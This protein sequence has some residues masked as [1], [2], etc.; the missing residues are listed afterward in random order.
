VGGY[1]RLAAYT[2]GLLSLSL[3]V[4]VGLIG[5]YSLTGE[6]LVLGRWICRGLSEREMAKSTHLM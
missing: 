3:F 4:V 6:G 2:Y 5:Y 1:V